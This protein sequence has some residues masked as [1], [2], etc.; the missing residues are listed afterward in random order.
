[1]KG[2]GKDLR[3]LAEKM[4]S[5]KGVSYGTLSAGTSGKKVH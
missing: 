3:A 4:I 5:L 1:M 2:K